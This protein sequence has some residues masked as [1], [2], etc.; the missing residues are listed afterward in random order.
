MVCS[1]D[2]LLWI[3]KALNGYSLNPNYPHLVTVTENAQQILTHEID[4]SIFVLRM[5]TNVRA[6]S[7]QLPCCSNLAGFQAAGC[8]LFCGM[9]SVLLP[10]QALTLTPEEQLPP[11]LAVFFTL[12]REM[13][14]MRG[15]PWAMRRSS[16]DPCTGKTA[17]DPFS[18]WLSLY[19]AGTARVR[20][21]CEWTAGSDTSL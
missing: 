12:C 18:G 17:S 19:T 9:S 15:L 3:F 10:L 20:P 6:R 7:S 13:V 21:L 8:C 4:H 14:R 1:C 11:T 16:W 5:L 2:S